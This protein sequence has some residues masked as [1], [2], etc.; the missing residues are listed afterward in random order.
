[1]KVGQSLLLRESNARQKLEKL[2][3]KLEEDV[4][5]KAERR[6]FED[7]LIY[8]SFTASFGSKTI[9]HMVWALCYPKPKARQGIF[10]ELELADRLT[11]A[12]RTVRSP[13]DPARLYAACLPAQS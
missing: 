11:R 3:L 12:S 1:M 7:I 13:F 8:F 2:G 5:R 6:K 10:L 4:K 9:S